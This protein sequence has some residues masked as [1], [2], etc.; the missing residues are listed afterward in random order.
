M[1]VL[2]LVDLEKSDIKWKPNKYPDG[3][4]DVVITPFM[5]TDHKIQVNF[6]MMATISSN[7]S[8]MIQSRLNNFEEISTGNFIVKQECTPEDESIGLL[9]TI[10]EDGKFYNQT[11]LTEI[12]NKL[13]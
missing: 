9:R 2:N 4:R 6:G 11:T 10:Y 5:I 3:Q 7:K 1:K 13:N 12:R 8:I